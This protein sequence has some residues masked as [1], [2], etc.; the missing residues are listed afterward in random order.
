MS[1]KEELDEYKEKAEINTR[2]A[3]EREANRK[4]NKQSD[5]SVFYRAIVC[6]AVL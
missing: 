3:Q 2:I 4:K 1:I 5:N 6:C